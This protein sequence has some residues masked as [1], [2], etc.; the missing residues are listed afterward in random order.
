MN[1]PGEEIP[2]KKSKIENVMEDAKVDIDWNHAACRPSFSDRPCGWQR[3]VIKDLDKLKRFSPELPKIT[4][5]LAGVAISGCRPMV[6]SMSVYNQAKALFGRV[7]QKREEHE[8]GTGP[9]P[10]VWEWATKFVNEFLPGFEAQPMSLDEWLDS[11]PSVRRKILK[12]A[13]EKYKRSGWQT[14]FGQFKAFVKTEL[15]PGFGKGTYDIDSAYEMIDRL[16]QAPND[17]AHVV[18]G[19]Y[20]KPL[21]HALKKIWTSDFY[22]HYGSN[23]PESNHEFL[24]KLVVNPGLYFWSDYTAFDNTHSAESWDFMERLYRR[25]GI[26]DPVFWRVMR[27][28]RRPV[29]RIGPFRYKGPVMNCSG[30]DDTALANGVLNGVCLYLSVAAAWLNKPM[31]LLTVNDVRSLKGILLLSVCGDDSLG[32]LPSTTPERALQ[33]KRDIVDNVA[34]FGFKAKLETSERL[35]DCVYLGQRPY[36][37]EKGWFW[38]KTIGR[39]V[40]KMGWILDKGQDLRAHMKGLAEMHVLCNS[41]VPILSDIARRI[42]ELTD[43]AKKTLPVC[44]PNRPWEWPFRSGV[45]YDNITLSAVADVYETTVQNL[46]A[47]IKAVQSIPCLPFV[48]DDWQIRDIVRRDDL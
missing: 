26:T 45:L 21:V 38:G 48:V 4:H 42:I 17:V 47:S 9:C 3:F 46:K 34:K 28:W 36:P 40:Y 14:S 35:I 13:A 30:R 44:D 5:S 6:S 23:S 27:A 33:L 19:P 8:W 39:A 1:V 37:T 32:R 43:G 31:R 22:I 16:I 20:L 15:L 12:M 10:G 18:V 2:P 7:F 25:A 29:G 11:M 24:Q 41:H